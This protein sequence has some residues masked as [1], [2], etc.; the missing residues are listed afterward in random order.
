MSVTFEEIRLSLPHIEVAAHLYG[1][2]DGQPVIALH[3]WLDNAATFSRLAPLLEGLRIVALDLPGHGHSDHRPLGAAYNIWDY[4]H[5]VLQTAEQF[6]WK[7]FS[8]L[9]HSMGA[10]VSVLLAGAMPERVERLALIDGVIPFTGEAETAPQK[11]G[12]SLQKLLAVDDKRKPVYAT[13]EQAVAARMKGVGAVSHE[14]AERLAQRGLMPVPGGYT[15]RTDARLMLPSSMRLT[16]AHAL[17]FVHC[18]ACPASLILAEQGLL[19]Q[20]AMVELIQTLPF[21][22]HRLPGGHHLHLDN[23]LGAE[24]V[25]AVFNPFFAG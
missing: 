7:R 9:G 10:I 24:A 13:F 25:A 2:E 8:L 4:A 16:R 23:Q 12:E 17:A 18:V 1:P 21:E 19:N 20:P 6:G 15:W 22:L 11:L 14:A 3:G 5:D